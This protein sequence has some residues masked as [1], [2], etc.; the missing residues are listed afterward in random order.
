MLEHYFLKPDTVD[1]IRESWIG[2]PIER[3]VTWLH[4]HGYAA[5][6]VY[7]RVPLLRQFGVFTQTQGATQW[8]ELPHYVEPFVQVWVQKHRQR[9]TTGQTCQHVE[10]DARNPIQQLLRLILPDYTGRGRTRWAEPFADRA[11]GFWTYL[12][13][14]RGLREATITAY[15]HSVRRLEKY[16]TH[17][18]LHAL[19]AVSPAVLSAFV[20]ESSQE[21]G[22][23]SVRVLCS[24][25]RMFVGYLYREELM[26]RDLRPAVAAP[27][28]YRLADL[29]R[30]ISWEEVGRLLEGVDRRTPMGK[31]DYAILLLLVT[32]GLRA[33]EIAALTLDDL[34]WYRDRLRVPER[35]AGHSTAYPLSPLVG[36]AL[37]AYLQHGRPQTSERTLFF[38]VH[39]PYAPITAVAISQLSKSHLCKAGIAV[40][41]A[42]SHTLRHTCV[43]RL[44][45]AG[46]DLKTIG[47]YVGH[48][49]PSA[50]TVYTKVDVEALRQVALG[51]GEEV[52]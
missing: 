35:K 47:D 7:R 28:T 30:S 50:T 13:Q 48:S 3:Y 26:V 25:L 51:D 18:D 41:R 34:D 24:H 11:P 5:R 8:E 10:S 20:T 23:A 37:V 36:E 31:R 42:G 1:R 27:R 9:C 16:L 19:S 29:P 32:Y 52:V 6:N 38:Q 46:F 45:D 21:L 22:K 39:A 40:P 15:L 49:S 44:V 17:I 4:E 14:E 2:E 33:R 12:R 43:Q